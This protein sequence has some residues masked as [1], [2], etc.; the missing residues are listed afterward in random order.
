MKKIIFI[1]L[2]LVITSITNAEELKIVGNGENSN[3]SINI[4]P[5]KKVVIEQTNV[6]DID[7]TVKCKTSTGGNTA[8][9]NTGNTTIVT[10]DAD[11]VVS[12][13]N[14]GNNNNN[15]NPKT[16]ITPT[17][18]PNPTVTPQQQN[19][20]TNGSNNPPTNGSDNPPNNN[21]NPSTTNPSHG[22][23]NPSGEI[24]G[25]A[26]TSGDMTTTLSTAAGIICLVLGSLILKSKS[27]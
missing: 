24:L 15:N 23:T 10:G 25:L 19:P 22:S 8:N 7:N 21:T 17:N 12:V 18:K 14:E 2:A 13:T 26:A 11:C 4:V 9:G 5:T 27:L 1:I 20:P 16:T 3:N 6:A